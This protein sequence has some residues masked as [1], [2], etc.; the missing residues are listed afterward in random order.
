MVFTGELYLEDNAKPGEILKAKA[1]DV[2]QVT[3]GTTSKWSTPTTC[4][5]KFYK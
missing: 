1:G 2:V 4:K 5:G 3:H